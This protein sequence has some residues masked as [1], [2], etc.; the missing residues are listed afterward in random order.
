M[1]QRAAWH[2]RVVIGPVKIALCS[3]VVPFVYGGARNIVEWLERMLQ[4]AGHQVERVY[5]P[6]VDA[7]DLLFQQMAAY[8]WV[9][10]TSCADRVICFRP[11]AHLIPHPHKTLWFIHHIRS[12]Y[13]LW[14]SPYRGFPDDARH[15]GIRDALRAADTAA[16]Q[17]AQRV[18][19]NSQVVSDRLQHF[20]GV[21]GEVLYPPIFQPERFKCRSFNDEIVCVSRLEH[22]KRQHLLI[23]ALKFT[24]TEVKLRLCGA[25]AGSAYPNDLRR[26]IG[27]ARLNDRVALDSRW[28][29]E[30]EKAEI[31]SD[32][33]AAAYLPLDEDSYGYPSLEASHSSKPVLTTTDSGGVLELVQN[34]FNGLVAEPEPQALAEAMDRLYLDRAA[35]RLMGENAQARPGDLN[36]SWAHVL[37]RLLA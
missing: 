31:L 34:G 6:Q 9:D 32:C 26:Q 37:D 2:A 33:L 14:D 7:P 3:S 35:T 19:T 30:T 21:G 16:L 10:L 27:E 15:R 22:H 23:E 29:S 4:E 8:R 20:N 25:G 12:F 1:A 28:I 36:I 18:F 5:L 17:E 13:D 24:R 11:P